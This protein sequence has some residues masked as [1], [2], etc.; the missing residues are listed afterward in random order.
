MRRRGRTAA[1]AGL[2]V[3]LALLSACGGTK[4]TAVSTRLQ[5]SPTDSRPATTAGTIGATSTTSSAGAA[6]IGPTTTPTKGSDAG[7]PAATAPTA[8][9]AVPK[10]DDL[11]RRRDAPPAGVPA[12][13][14]FLAPTDGCVDAVHPTPAVEVYDTHQIGDS[15]LICIRGFD[16]SP[17]VS[18]EVS[19]PDGRKRQRP[20][21]NVAGQNDWMFGIGATDPTGRYDV[22]A[23]QGAKR[24]TAGFTVKLP[25]QP[26]I[27]T[28]SAAKG[29]AGTTFRFTVVSP[30]PNQ[31]VSVDLYRG[32]G[33]Q[34]ATTVGTVTTDGQARATYQLPTFAD[35]PTGTYCLVARPSN[36]CADFEVG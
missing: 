7:G 2:A 5:P 36:R 14:T 29:R 16:P 33:S 24:A 25:H 30:S 19:L 3:A 4:D 15:V 18:M 35:A 20:V 31:T 6:R 1:V 9:V 26:L 13:L 17:P 22:T 34:Y 8:T 21:A 32:H 12:Q 23:V 28:L 27:F 11:L 10:G